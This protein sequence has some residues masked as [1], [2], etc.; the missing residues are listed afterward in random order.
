VRAGYNRQTMPITRS[1]HYEG[2]EIYLAM[3]DAAVPGELT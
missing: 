1:H 2:S 3:V